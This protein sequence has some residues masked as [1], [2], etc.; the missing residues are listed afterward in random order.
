M[1]EQDWQQLLTQVNSVLD[2]RNA[3]S[4]YRAFTVL[5]NLAHTFVR[6]DYET[7]KPTFF[8]DDLGLANLM[9]KSREDLRIVSVIDLEWSY[10][11]PSQLAISAP[12]WLLMDRPTHISWDCRNGIEPVELTSRYFRALDIYKRVL[13]EEETKLVGPDFNEFSDLVQWSQD[14]GAMWLH[15]LLVDCCLS[16]DLFPFHRLIQHVGKE[17]WKSLEDE[18]DA[19]EV[20]NFV[21]AR[22]LQ[23]KQYDAELA[24]MK[25]E[26][27][28]IGR[29]E[30]STE[31]FVTKYEQTLVI[32]G[33]ISRTLTSS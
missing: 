11:A 16:Y 29:G 5:K 6:P 30:M 4:N 20:G 28:L 17:K 22:M 33:P 26:D 1:L 14:S 3:S 19:N 25:A 13:R 27:E 31:D 32:P 24:Q 23:R 2:E 21:Q 10:A 15:M 9:V 8:C 18:I 12:W 7:K